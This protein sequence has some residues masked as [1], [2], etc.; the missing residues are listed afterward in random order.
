M[1]DVLTQSMSTVRSW[2]LAGAGN[3]TQ[4]GEENTGVGCYAMEHCSTGNY[5]TALGAYALQDATTASENTAVGGVSLRR[6]TTGDMNTAV[7]SDSLTYT[8][9]GVG[10]TALGWASGM[11][12][13]SGSH[14]TL[15]G[16]MADVSAPGLTNAAAIGASAKVGTSDTLVLGGTGDMAVKILAGSAN[17]D[18]Y[19]GHFDIRYPYSPRSAN[20]RAQL[21]VSDNGTG[22]VIDTGGALDLGGYVDSFACAY[23]YARI[24]GLSS[25]ASGFG[26][27]LSFQSLNGGGVLVEAMRINEFSNVGIGTVTP[28][29]RLAV[30]GL[31]EHADNAAAIASGLSLGD[32]YRTGDALKVVH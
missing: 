30:V 6:I 10:N 29:A 31:T 4:T 21:F 15:V 3:A 12:N 26:G 19:G 28:G 9:I 11:G 20:V 23:S 13:V 24:A 7:G 22:Q 25:V 18:P 2:F 8:T 32:F 1:Y 14:T 5:N 27:Y 16:H 17:S